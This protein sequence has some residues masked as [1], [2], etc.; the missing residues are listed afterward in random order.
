MCDGSTSVQVIEEK[1][2]NRFGLEAAPF[3]ERLIAFLKISEANDWIEWRG[4]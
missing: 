3:R 4:S 2:K 1:I